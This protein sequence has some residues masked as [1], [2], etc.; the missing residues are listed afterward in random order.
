MTLYILWFTGTLGVLL[1]KYVSYIR[2]GKVRRRSLKRATF[3]WFFEPSLM[4]AA[5]W[6]STLS[7]SWLC[8]AVYIDKIGFPLLF[9]LLGSL[10]PH[11]AIA[12]FL[13]IIT[14]V[15]APFITKWI[16]TKADAVISLVK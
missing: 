9:D 10:E 8:S 16:I 4:N 5:S 7:A 1:Y 6:F 2:Y 13:G 11:G 14:E 12:L 15:I 3:D